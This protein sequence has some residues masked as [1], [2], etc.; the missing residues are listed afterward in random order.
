MR[1]D[2]P[3]LLGAVGL[4]IVATFGGLSVGLPLLSAELTGSTTAPVLQAS[5]VPVTFTVYGVVSLAGAVG[6]LAGWA[7]ATIVVV[8]TQ[9][10]VVLGLLWVYVALA[11]D[12]SLLIVAA[13]AGGAAACALLDRRSRRTT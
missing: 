7:R 3:F 11:A 13:V 12:W 10:V 4:L 5:F 8:V 6:L 9:G 1:T 2:R